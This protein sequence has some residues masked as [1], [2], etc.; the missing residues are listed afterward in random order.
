MAEQVWA[1]VF[2]AVMAEVACYFPRRD[3]ACWHGR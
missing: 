2:V 1:T 3:S